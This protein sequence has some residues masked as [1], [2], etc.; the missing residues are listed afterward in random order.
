MVL[1]RK[2]VHETNWQYEGKFGHA[3]GV[4]K[5]KLIHIAEFKF[6]LFSIR[7]TLHMAEFPL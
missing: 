7:K 1:K 3:Q 6:V 2:S 5:R 4:L